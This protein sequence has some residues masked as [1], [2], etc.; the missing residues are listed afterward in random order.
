M[1]LA[2]ASLFALAYLPG[3]VIFRLPLAG[4]A[5]RAALPAEERVFWAVII[6]LMLTTLAALG[7]AGAGVFTLGHLLAVDAGITVLAIAAGRRDLLLGPR[8]PRVTRSALVPAALIAVGLYLFFPS[9]EYIMGGKDPGTYINEGTQIAQHGSWVIPDPTVAA[10]PVESL[11]QFLWGDPA[12]MSEGLHQGARFMGFYVR[13]LDRGEVIGQFPHAYPVWIAIGYD[14]FGLRGATGAVGFWGLVGLMAVYFC[15]SRLV[16]RMAACA[17]TA[18]LAL[19]VAEIWYARYP[20]SELMQQ[21]L[22]FAALLAMAR[23]LQDK[24]AFFAPV[25]GGL[26]GLLLF[27]RV[28]AALQL[29]AVGGGV[30]LT[31]A[32]GKRPRLSFYAP[33]AT[34][35]VLAGAYYLGPMKAYAAIPLGFMRGPAGV[36]AGVAALVLL[37]ILIHNVRER[38][39][40]ALALGQ[41][42]LP[43]VLVFALAAV[44]LYGFFLRAPFENVRDA[45]TRI[46]TQQGAAFHDAYSLRIYAWY[47]GVAGL[48]AAVVGLAVVTWASFWRDPVVLTVTIA[49]SSFFFYRTRIVPEHFWQARRY[50]TVILPMTCVL[51]AAGALACEPW[52]RAR[53]DALPVDGVR[54]R[55]WPAATCLCAGAAFLVWLGCQSIGTADPIRNHVEYAGLTAQ[56]ETLSQRF[57]DR[58]LVLIESRNSSDAH[59]V[60]VPLAYI[61]GRN[62]LEMTA[63]RPERNA[64]E[65]FCLWAL[66]RYEHVYFVADGGTDMPRGGMA[67][68]PVGS[69]AFEVPEFESLYNA[70]PRH[71]RYKKFSLSVFQ[72]TKADQPQIKTDIDIGTLDDVWVLRFFAKERTADS[73]TFRWVRNM[74]YVS[75]WGI[76]PDATRVTLRMSDGGRP[77]VAGPARL[78]AFLNDDSLGTLVVTGDFRDYSLP[79]PP[80]VA[81]KA[82]ARD[83]A[84]VLRLMC[85]TWVPKE[86]FGGTDDR[87][88]GVMLNH[89]RVER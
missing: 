51:A 54:P 19:N 11:S 30:L 71:V 57:G 31:V 7:L 29:A 16:G 6:S 53:R 8:A 56:I 48:F 83:G 49:L 86:S 65:R 12:E 37:G 10:V 87:Q 21:A 34:L 17:G 84:S 80:E 63:P 44:F 22:L 2:V 25:A 69:Q 45:A 9:A 24:D 72:I 85:T 18:L 52:W 89:V 41:R 40:P 64:F 66:S 33:L 79:I 35:F 60:A 15:A 23:M 76:S 5:R 4:R 28:D 43:R 39:Q 74:S 73:V 36:C 77:A 88:V 13:S 58:D 20:N 81:R 82:A 55:V 62:V 50:L 70:Y 46:T 14:L 67:F 1:L 59:V 61:Y 42:W 27:V 75:L 32:D 47:V 78:E 68:S 38:V 3:A 26:L